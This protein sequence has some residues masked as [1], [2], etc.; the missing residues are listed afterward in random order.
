MKAHA[1]VER[2][3]K[4][5]YSIF[6]KE[7]LPRICVLG[8]GSSLHNAIKDFWICY[9]EMKEMVEDAPEIEVEFLTF[10]CGKKDRKRKPSKKGLRLVKIKNKK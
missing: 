10:L 8:Y 1:I 2:T 9:E 4:G 7:M 3:T 5:Y 6:T